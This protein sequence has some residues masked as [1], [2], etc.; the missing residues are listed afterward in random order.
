VLDETD[1]ENK[2]VNLGKRKS[3]KIGDQKVETQKGL[4]RV[5]PRIKESNQSLGIIE[6]SLTSAVNF[7]LA[8]ADI[9]Q[10]DVLDVVKQVIK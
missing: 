1:W 10:C 6:H 3:M 5:D 9:I 7:T 4:T 8:S 2:V